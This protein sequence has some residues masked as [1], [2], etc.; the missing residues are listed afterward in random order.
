MGSTMQKVVRTAL[1]G[2][3]IAVVVGCATSETKVSCDGKLTPIN[4][5][6]AK[7]AATESA[8]HQSSQGT[9]P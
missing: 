3:L 9:A 2:S 8:A 1:V 5:P 4:P 7:V 6:A